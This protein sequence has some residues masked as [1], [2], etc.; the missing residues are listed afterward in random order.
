[1]LL[2][3]VILLERTIRFWRSFFTV[4]FSLAVFSGMAQDN[5]PYSR[6]GLGDIVPNT[7]ITLRGM[8]GISAG[9]RDSRAI[10]FNNPASYSSFEVQRERVTNRVEYGRVLF[11]V[12]V[13]ID[14]RTLRAP[15]TP[16]KFT[17]T[18]AQ[19]S[20]LQL[21]IPLR[22][23][24]GLNVG[25]RPV[26]RVNYKINR[27]ERIFD[28]L[29]SQFID[30]AVTEFT[31]DGGT[32]LPSIGTGFAISK[33][34][35][36]VNVGYLFGKKEVESRRGIVN[37]SVNYNQAHFSSNNSFG[38]LFFNAGAQYVINLGKTTNITLGVNGNWKQDLKARQ[39]VLRETFIRNVDGQDFQLDSVFQQNDIEGRI[40]FPSNL[41]YGFT[42]NRNISPDNPGRR[43]WTF[44]A[45][46]I[47]NN[48]SEFTSFGAADS[49][50]NNWEFR[51]GGQLNPS[52]RHYTTRGY[53]QKVSYRAGFFMGTD[54][55]NIANSKGLIQQMP[56]MGFTFGVGL[57]VPGGNRFSFNQTS[58]VNLAFEFSRR[59][60]NESRLKENMFRI[61]AG[62]SLSDVWFGKR[63]YD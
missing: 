22:E 46:Y 25:L 31:G 20:Y 13:N 59:G 27:T 42:I 19:I 60:D 35:I 29:S 58:V 49:L 37:D 30:T 6:F 55:I 28:P 43:G 24:W 18:S 3:K 47:Q 1:M 48:W 4:L 11:D 17:S 36:G 45:D 40:T 26:T 14:S 52:L 33:F 51:V 8:G 5:S 38:G 41:T 9:Y 53:A 2:A 34:S 12:G 63:R 50:A 10:N 15:N 39:D 56:K 57:P 32:F 7:N 44:G 16:A 23:N 61:A 54:Y 62:F 21:G